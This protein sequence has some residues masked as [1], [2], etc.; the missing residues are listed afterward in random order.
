MQTEKN[1]L[2]AEL[3]QITA[4]AGTAAKKFKALTDDQLNYKKSA[5]EWSI[6]ECIEHLNLYGDF[7]LPEIEKQMLAQGSTPDAAIFKSGFL[8]NYF[9]K[10]LKV[11]DGKIKKMKS[12]KDKN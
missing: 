9:A 1:K 4:N 8:G 11:N 12:P 6:L 7:Y 2:I 3:L 10:V 5:A